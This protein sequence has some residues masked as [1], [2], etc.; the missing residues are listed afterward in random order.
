MSKTF[1]SIITQAQIA[2]KFLTKNNVLSLLDNAQEL[3]TNLEWLE[4]KMIEF[5]RAAMNNENA[6]DIYQQ[7]MIAIKE[8]D[9]TEENLN[10]WIEEIFVTEFN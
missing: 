4:M 8:I 1:A 9:C 2:V 7:M 6:G 5:N 3:L 10:N